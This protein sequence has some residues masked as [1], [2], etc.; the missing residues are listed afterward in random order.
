MNNRFR[1]GKRKNRGLPKNK[2]R[3]ILIILSSIIVGL[4]IV[5]LG[6]AVYFSR[7]FFIN[8]EVNGKDFSGKSAAA[9]ENYMREQVK[10]YELKIIEQNNEIDAIKGSDISLIYKENSDIDKALQSQNPLLWAKAFFLRSSAEVSIEVGYDENALIKEIKSIK[11]VTREQTDSIPAYPKYDGNSFVV[12]PEVYG[13]KVDMDMLTQKITEYI[14]EFKSELN[15]MDEECY[16]LPKYSSESPEVQE[17]CDIM[18]DYLK[19]SITYKMDK[20]IVVDKKLISTWLTYNDK[21]KVTLDEKKVREWMREFGE[22]YDTVK[23]TRSITTPTG[24]TTEVSGGTYGWSVDE[25]KET[26]ALIE[27][28][29][30]GEIVEK[31]P[32]YEQTAASR[33]AQDWGETYIEV[34]ISVQHMWYIVEGKIAF[35]ADVVTGLPTKN[36]ETP[37]GVY[38]ILE[39]KRDKTLVGE[40]N[41]ST[42]KPSY[43]TPVSYWMRVTWTGIGFHDAIWQPYFGGEL[44]KANGSHG[45][46]NMSLGEAEK[47]YSM[48]SVGDPVIIHY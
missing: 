44:Y 14:T 16:V 38:S 11:A 42:G 36:R 20:D 39:K 43:K 22:T 15:M 12:E 18:N 29:K 45:C 4:L 8:T 32:A 26:K 7:H 30:K 19:A 35:E 33:S 23:K 31:K 41:P 25:E 1:R 10:G 2:L 47:L 6:I 3:K 28:I 13:T 24:K 40:T 17:A 34:D 27:S 21:M 48:I 46:I 9:V 5:Y 37:Q